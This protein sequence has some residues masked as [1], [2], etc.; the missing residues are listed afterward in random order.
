MLVFGYMIDASDL[1]GFC[2]VLLIRLENNGKFY[3]LMVAIV[4]MGLRGVPV[5]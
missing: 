2:T 5:C 1:I 4:E 3:T